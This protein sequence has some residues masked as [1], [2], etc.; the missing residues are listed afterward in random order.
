MPT[1]LIEG[2]RL[3]TQTKRHLVCQLTDLVA[4]AYEWPPDNIVIIFR[5]NSDENVARGGKLLMDSGRPTAPV[6]S[7]KRGE[8][9]DAK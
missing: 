6:R 4:K 7:N 1:I 5:E 9:G 3:N 8:S 2:P